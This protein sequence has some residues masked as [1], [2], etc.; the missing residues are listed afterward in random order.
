MKGAQFL[1]H[2]GFHPGKLFSVIYHLIASSLYVYFFS[3]GVLFT[4][5]GVYPLSLFS[6]NQKF[7]CVSKYFSHLILTAIKSQ[8][9][10]SVYVLI[11]TI[12][13][14]NLLFL[15]G[16]HG[17]LAFMYFHYYYYY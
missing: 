15:E 16:F 2:R 5:N 11:R 17:S 12:I 1:Q 8:C 6:S 10:S 7:Y 13:I 14:F 9:S 3:S 4:I